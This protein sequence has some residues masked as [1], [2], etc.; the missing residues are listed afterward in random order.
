MLNKIFYFCIWINALSLLL[1]LMFTQ[2]MFVFYIPVQTRLFSNK[3]PE[4][5]PQ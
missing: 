4:F 2:N 3:P 1:Y 5:H